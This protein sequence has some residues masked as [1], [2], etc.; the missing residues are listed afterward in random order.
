MMYSVLAAEK[1]EQ[2]FEPAAV[3]AAGTIEEI[4]AG[5]DLEPRLVL[6]DEL[7]HELAVEPMQVVERVDQACSGCERRGTA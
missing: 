5:Q 6:H 2:L 4:R 1:A 3:V 7:A